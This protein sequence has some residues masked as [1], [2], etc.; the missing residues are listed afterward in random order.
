MRPAPVAREPDAPRDLV[1]RGR[2]T[3]EASA[4][5]GDESK[6]TATPRAKAI[7]PALR[8]THLAGARTVIESQ[9]RGREVDV[10]IGTIEI[11]AETVSPVAAPPAP[12]ASAA[13]GR[14]Q[15]G[16][17]DFVRLRTYAPWER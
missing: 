13:V 7:E 11:H 10:R 14:P 2:S 16:F 12:L 9:G 17:D 3:P 15:G 1:Q 6:G 8:Q 4:G 5:S